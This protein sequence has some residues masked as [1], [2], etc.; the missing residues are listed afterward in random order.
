MM[1]EEARTAIAETIVDIDR[2]MGQLS[3]GEQ[4]KL[5]RRRLAL[6]EVLRS[7]TITRWD[8]TEAKPQP[9]QSA[10]RSTRRR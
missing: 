6:V 7:N 4:E 8:R 2:A 10:G 3:Q 5:M 9:N 1:G